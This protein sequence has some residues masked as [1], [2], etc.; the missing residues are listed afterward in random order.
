[1]TDPTIQELFDLTDRVALI[2]GAS[3]YLG[4][5]MAAGLA[6]AGARVIVG[7]RNLKQAEESAAA[8]PCPDREHL[9]VELEYLDPAEVAG[10]A[11]RDFFDAGQTA[12]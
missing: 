6:E 7:S 10:L 11:R 12:E 3:G 1:M 9:G 4:S 8:L 5:A 2:T